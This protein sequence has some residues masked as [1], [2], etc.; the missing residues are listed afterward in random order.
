MYS[1]ISMY[2]L[3]CYT[4][5]SNT[6]YEWTMCY[7]YISCRSFIQFLLGFFYNRRTC[8]F[9]ELVLGSNESRPTPIEVRELQS[10]PPPSHPSMGTLKNYSCL[11]FSILLFYVKSH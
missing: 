5:G 1:S 10:P 9:A 11:S 2:G 7:I 8:S 4:P 6:T 3:Q